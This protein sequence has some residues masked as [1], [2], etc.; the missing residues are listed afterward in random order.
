VRAELRRHRVELREFRPE[1]VAY[2]REVDGLFLM[3]VGG[4]RDAEF[5]YALDER[6]A[7]LWRRD[8]LRDDDFGL[9]LLMIQLRRIRRL[10]RG[11]ANRRVDDVLFVRVVNRQRVGELAKETLA[12][13]RIARSDDPIDE[14]EGGAVLVLE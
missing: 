10:V 9:I 7:V 13:T 2:G 6:G 4:E 11:I 3:D 5:L 8:Q 1:R 14:S 12:L